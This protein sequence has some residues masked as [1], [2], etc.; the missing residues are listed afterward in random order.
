MRKL[1]RPTA[2]VD[3]PFGCHGEVAR[4]AG[5]LNWFSAVELITIEENFRIKT[6][7]VSVAALQHRLDDDLGK[8]WQSITRPASN[9]SLGSRIV[10][11]DQPQVMGIINAT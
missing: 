9:L 10:R 8:Q 4:L 1:I 6:E 2:F 11:L 3:N 7:L 5:G